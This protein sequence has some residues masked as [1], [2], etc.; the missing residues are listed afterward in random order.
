M[1]WFL[2]LG[3]V[4]AVLITTPHHTTPHHTQ[5]HST[6]TTQKTRTQRHQRTK[7][8]EQRTKNK[9]QRTKNKE[10]RTKNQEPRTKNQEPRTKNQEPRTKKKA[11][12]KK[13]RPKEKSIL[14]GRQP[15]L[16]AL[17]NN[18][19]LE[20]ILIKRNLKGEIIRDIMI[21]AREL[22]IPIQIVPEEKLN[23]YTTKNHQ[24]VL[25]RLSIIP[26]A[27]LEDILSD[28]YDKG[29]MPLFFCWI[30]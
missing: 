21:K 1:L 19:P 28:V 12:F 8:K 26:F 20:K 17:N 11:M 25:A 4:V 29:E 27:N 18:I 23:W 6:T 15:M 22:H 9:E 7:N 24:G 30:K 16:E 14:F 2:V 13:K 5:N 3:A 10:Q